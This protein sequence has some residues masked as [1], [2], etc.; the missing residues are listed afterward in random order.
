MK[1]SHLL[2]A[3]SDRQLIEIFQNGDESAFAALLDRHRSRLLAI[4]RQ[5]VRDE[6]AAEDLL[7]ETCIRLLE[8]LRK[9]SYAES[10]RFLPW[11]LRIARNLAI[12][13][14]RRRQRSAEVPAP[15]QSHLLEQQYRTWETPEQ[16][17]CS[18]EDRTYVGQWIE[19]LPPAQ[20]EV[21]CL[22]HYEQLTFREIAER[23]NVSINTALGRMRYALINLR[24][25]ADQS[26]WSA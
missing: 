8:R 23:T 11:A 3:A 4:I 18:T 26:A 25:L 22:R 24:K 2:A 13:S 7:Q 9:G 6:A 14:Y 17:W 5:I 19:Q 15:E 10:D 16:L 12:D 21:L 1:K 20:R